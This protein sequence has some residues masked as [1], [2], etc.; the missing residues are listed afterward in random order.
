MFLKKTSIF[1]IGL[2][3]FSQI[4]LSQGSPQI[5]HLVSNFSAAIERLHKNDPNE[6]PLVTNLQK[7]VDILSDHLFDSKVKPDKLYLDILQDDYRVLDSISRRDRSD[8]SSNKTLRVVL[9]DLQIKNKSLGNSQ[10]IENYDFNMPVEVRTR[11][12]VNGVFKDIS[13]YKIYANPWL[14]KQAKPAKIVFNNS[15]NPGTSKSL[16]PGL[17]YFWATP[18]TDDSIV[19]PKLINYSQIDY[20]SD[21]SKQVIYIDVN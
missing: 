13:G 19:Y 5:S 16:P 11:Q 15:T 14:T 18:I 7:E 17:Y 6:S 3:V 10:L 8:T 4:A 9:L 20:K 1:I 12:L 2:L 21:K